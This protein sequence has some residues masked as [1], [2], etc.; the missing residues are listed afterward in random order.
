[1]FGAKLL[2]GTEA[3]L[4]FLLVAVATW[5]RSRYKI[6]FIG[7]R[8]HE[9]IVIKYDGKTGINN[10]SRELKYCNKTIDIYVLPTLFETK[11]QYRVE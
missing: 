3:T 6:V 2:H 9:T 11:F 8:H 1:M 10:N 5:D 7:E 4:E